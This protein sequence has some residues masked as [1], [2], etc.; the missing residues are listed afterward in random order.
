MT[1]NA[2]FLSYLSSNI[3]SIDVFK[4]PVQKIKDLNEVV[5]SEFFFSFF[6]FDTEWLRIQYNIQLL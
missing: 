6:A 1:F 5:I 4:F 3:R 2:Y